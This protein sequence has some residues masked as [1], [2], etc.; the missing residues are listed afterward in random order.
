MLLTSRLPMGKTFYDCNFGSANI[1]LT[2]GRTNTRLA[3]ES[4][5]TES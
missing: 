4:D 3:E 5:D 1:R 2:E